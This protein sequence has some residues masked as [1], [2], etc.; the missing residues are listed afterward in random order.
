[1]PTCLEVQED[2][3]NYSETITNNYQKAWF[4]V[5]IK[6]ASHFITWNFQKVNFTH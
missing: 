4:K 3:E 5:E 2:L 1:M 6:V